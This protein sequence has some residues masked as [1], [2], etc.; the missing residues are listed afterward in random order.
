MKLIVGNKNL[1]HLYMDFCEINDSHIRKMKKIL[2]DPLKC[3]LET[4]SFSGNQPLSKKAYQSFLDILHYNEAICDLSPPR[5]SEEH[6]LAVS[7]NQKKKEPRERQAF[8]NTMVTLGHAYNSKPSADSKLPLGMITKDVFLKIMDFLGENAHM[9]ARDIYLC[10]LLILNNFRMRRTLM[11]Q[12][13]YAPSVGHGIGEWWAKSININKAEQ[14]IF[15]PTAKMGLF[16][17]LVVVD[18]PE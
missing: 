12:K 8:I 14:K 18:D 3:H 2:I 1:K 10:N 13:K 16:K 17:P 9:S 4:F 5:H 6:R 15:K 7:I 11:D